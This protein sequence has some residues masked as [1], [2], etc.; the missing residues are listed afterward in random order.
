MTNEARL[1]EQAAA[2]GFRLVPERKLKE[3]M[4]Q[5]VH[6]LGLRE[7][8]AVI[9]VGANTGQ[10]ATS[11]R[12]LGWT[13]PILSIEPLPDAHEALARQAAADPLWTV[14]PR[15]AAAEC[16]SQVSLQVSA[17]GDMSS[18]LP[19]TALLERLS[20]SSAV[21]EIIVV[22]AHR[23]DALAA[24]V[25]APWQRLFVKIDVQGAEARVLDGMSRL[26]P[27]VAGVQIE[28]SLVELYEGEAPWRE[29]IDRLAASGFAPGLWIPG[30]YDRHSGRQL[31]MDVVF[32]RETGVGGAWRG[33]TSVPT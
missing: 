33:D 8:D 24:I 27:R 21:R 19:Q 11:L 20:P 4:V 16:S 31:Q 2:L 17:E 12:A 7:V 18:L 3:P 10:Y 23:L 15:M 13:G 26:W 32:F 6:A 29:T 22:E 28:L 9:D 1:R 14:A 5:L 25:Q 30:Y